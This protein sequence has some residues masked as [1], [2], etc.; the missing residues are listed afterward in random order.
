MRHLP[1]HKQVW[2]GV[3]VAVT[4][5][6][7]VRDLAQL[8]KT[9]PVLAEPL[10]APSLSSYALNNEA[11]L[12]GKINLRLEEVRTTVGSGGYPAWKPHSERLPET[13]PTGDVFHD[14]T[15]D[16]RQLPQDETL[17]RFAVSWAGGVGEMMPVLVRSDPGTDGTKYV[18]VEYHS[19][20]RD[21][22]RK[23]SGWRAFK[24]GT[25]KANVDAGFA[26]DSDTRT[27]AQ[28][29]VLGSLGVSYGAKAVWTASHDSYLTPVEI[30][31][32]ENRRPSGSGIYCLK[33]FTID[34]WGMKMLADM[35]QITLS[36]KTT[37]IRVP[38]TRF[39]SWRDAQAV[40]VTIT[41]YHWARFADV[42]LSIPG[43]T[44]H[45][46]P[47]PITREIEEKRV[48]SE[49]GVGGGAVGDYNE[50]FRVS[51]DALT[52]PQLAQ[53]VPGT[54]TLTHARKAMGST[55][56]G[57][58]RTETHLY[59]FVPDNWEGVRQHLTMYAVTRSGKRVRADSRGYSK[60]GGGM[61]VD[62]QLS[63][64]A[65]EDVAGVSFGL[66]R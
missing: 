55:D 10:S 19:D 42:P 31:L 7:F 3:C 32:P 45:A 14:D 5:P 61:R 49:S 9:P 13:P 17:Y 65:Y 60:E 58:S 63:E 22:R 12:N 1:K 38:L 24:K 43:D 25:R 30:T 66:T 16:R 64:V 39:E 48:A 62:F 37:S 4:L 6:F 2:I 15:L 35:R 28:F 34:R 11:S 33:T 47:L 41:P 40:R 50:L 20:D 46:N 27:L 53:F 52:H 18:R 57:F 36:S 26:F 54:V 21:G 51:H 44:T 29:P 59:A 8:G 23:M 56:P